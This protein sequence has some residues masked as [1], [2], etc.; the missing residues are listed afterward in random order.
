MYKTVFALI[1]EGDGE[2]RRHSALF[3]CKNLGRA[4]MV[5]TENMLKQSQISCG[6][7]RPCLHVTVTGLLIL[8][9]AGELSVQADEGLEDG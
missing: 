4:H 7:G 3:W 6:D 1:G 9:R 8:V 5:L 2:R